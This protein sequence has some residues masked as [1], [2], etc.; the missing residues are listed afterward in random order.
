M[1]TSRGYRL[2]TSLNGT[3]TGYGADLIVLDDPQKPHEALSEARHK[4]AA[5]V[6]RYH[7]VVQP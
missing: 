5:A 3:L 6:V 2:K 4:A 1:I 7:P